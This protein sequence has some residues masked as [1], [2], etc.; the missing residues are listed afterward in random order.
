MS[1]SAS[2]PGLFSNAF[3]TSLITSAQRSNIGS[4]GNMA[5]SF[6]VVGGSL[7]GGALGGGGGATFGG[8]GVTLAGNSAVSGINDFVSQIMY[9]STLRKAG[10][11]PPTGNSF[12]SFGGGFGG[13]FGAAV[14]ASPEQHLMG[15]LMTLFTMLQSAMQGGQPQVPVAQPQFAQTQFAQPQFAQ[16]QFVQPQLV[17]P[18]V[19]VNPFQSQLTGVAGTSGFGAVPS[20]GGFGGGFA[21]FGQPAGGIFSTVADGFSR[22]DAS[23]NNALGGI[24]ST[25]PLAKL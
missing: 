11:L 17:Q 13:G 4:L 24:L 12:N 1:L 25:L 15:Q 2:I 6:G 21:A 22:I 16:P 9:T 7:G 5:N 18:Q 10:L 19:A 14:P 20:A 23:I 3:Q 8:G